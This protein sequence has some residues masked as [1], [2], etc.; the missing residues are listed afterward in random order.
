LSYDA[1]VKTLTV[2]LPDALVTEIE[3]ESRFRRVSKS[4]V[5]RE[6]LHRRPR[7]ITEGGTM[8][9]LAGDLI[10]SVRGLPANLSREGKKNLPELIRAKNLHH[11]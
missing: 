6:R 10:G 8:R 11:R 2:R 3:H 1:F 4:D 5:V 9:D 7:A